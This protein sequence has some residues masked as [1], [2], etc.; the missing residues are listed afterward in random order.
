VKRFK[1]DD[2]SFGIMKLIE[3]NSEDSTTKLLFLLDDSSKIET[4]VIPQKTTMTICV[5]TQ[6][7]CPVGCKF[8]KSGTFYKRNLT[9][10]EILSQISFALEEFPL[11]EKKLS[12]VFMGIGEPLLN[13]DN[14]VPVIENLCVSR[15]DRVSKRRITV[16]TVGIPTSIIALADRTKHI[17]DTDNSTVNLAV[18]LHFTLDSLRKKYIP[19]AY[20]ISEILSACSTFQSL[21]SKKQFI[22]FEYIMLSGVNDSI[23]DIERLIALIKKYELRAI[24]NLIPYNGIDFKSTPDEKIKEYKQMIIKSGIKCFIRLSRGTGINA[25]CGMLASKK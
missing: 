11:G 24:V 10:D 25:A 20:P 17:I 23:A 5:S 6:V 8:C 14:L 18:S 1:N 16:S 3:K 2:E 15:K 13:M 21:G 9:T 19:L 7:G 12:I 4:V 22:M